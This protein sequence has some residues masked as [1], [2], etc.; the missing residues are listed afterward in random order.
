MSR[1]PRP[2][3]SAL[4]LLALAAAAAA[5][6]ATTVA[7]M[8]TKID[9]PTVSGTLVLDADHP[10]AVQR[11]TVSI[12]DIAYAANGTASIKFS[13]TGTDSIRL[14]VMPIQTELESGSAAGNQNPLAGTGAR[15]V[16]L[17]SA[18]SFPI[19][20][21]TP[22][23]RSFRVLAQAVGA[24]ANASVT[25]QASGSLLYMGSFWPSGAGMAMA[26]DDPVSVGGAGRSLIAD[27]PTDH[28]VL[29]ATHPAA[30]RLFEVRLAASAVPART[31]DVVTTAVLDASFGGT[32]AG[33]NVSNSYYGLKLIS[34]DPASA[35]HDRPVQVPQFEPFANCVPGKDCLATYLLTARWFGGRPET[36]DWS[37][38]LSQIRL[39]GEPAAPDSLQ[40]RVIR[41]FDIDDASPQTLHLEGDVTLKPGDGSSLET[42]ASVPLAVRPADPSAQ[43]P[44][45]LDLLPIPAVV[46]FEAS[47][48]SGTTLDPR[49][50]PYQRLSSYYLPSSNGEDLGA[51]VAPP[52]GDDHPTPAAPISVQMT[53]GV[54]QDKAPLT[55]PVTVHWA[56]DL[57]VYRYQGVPQLMPVAGP[58]ETPSPT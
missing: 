33:G 49:N 56:L 43:S 29:D 42:W 25:W 48:P 26:V 40:T 53:I 54:T 47:L 27:L 20:C 30:A 36:V 11:L 19:D 24:P 35:A 51:I 7:P 23:D 55:A 17:S 34:L 31:S 50:V 6:L 22:C 21:S 46:R 8:E 32:A 52:F 13:R 37:L 4:A 9:G 10:I 18:E 16:G 14:T 2:L 41:S 45:P 58:I 15:E 38:H 39:Q 57:D 28:I 5:S 44:V 1:R 12:N 3:R